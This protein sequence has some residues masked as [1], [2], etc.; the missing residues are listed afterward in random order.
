MSKHPAIETVV[1]R[2]KTDV[3]GGAA[4]TAKEVVTAL[5][6][7]VQD[8]QAS[9]KEGFIGEVNAAVIDILRVMPSLAPPINAMHRIIGAMEEALLKKASVPE[10]K[11]AIKQSADDF[12]TSIEGALDRVAQYG[13][14]KIRD[15]DTVFMY[16]MSS[17]VWRIL[18]RAKAQGK[19]LSVVVTESRPANEGLWTVTEME[20]DGIP[21]SVSIDACIGELIPQ[22]DV[23]FVGADAISSH[24]TA[25]CKVGTYPS[26]LVAHA[27]GV[28]FYI[29]ADTLKFDSSTLLGLPFRVDPIHWHEVLGDQQ[30]SDLV[31]VSGYLFDE[32][33]A[34][35]VTAII[36]EL[37]L[38]NP[39]ACFSVMWQMKLSQQLS[40]MLPAWVKNE[41]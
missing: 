27:H 3:I 38:L 25:L 36:T 23:V 35:L 1:E 19:S 17:T 15:G 24:G 14:E 9:D 13:A 2:I 16:S 20:K 28:P 8:S 30:Y 33:P 21:V 11:A 7:L 29:A 32:T 12:F 37:G 18:R 10:I 4:D 34:N 5:V 31:K 6:A 26:A 41:L 39:A 22:C 40:A